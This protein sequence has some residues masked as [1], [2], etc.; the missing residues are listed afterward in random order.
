MVSLL[1]G[2]SGDMRLIVRRSRPALQ[3]PI[4]A[5]CNVELALAFEQPA[6][7]SVQEGLA[8]IAAEARAKKEN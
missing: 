3:A 4:K 2:D 7:S 6:L 8:A 1:F 5:R